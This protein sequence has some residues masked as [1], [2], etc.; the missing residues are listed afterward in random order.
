MYISGEA[1]NMKRDSMP[2]S[3]RFTKQ[4][5]QLLHKKC[6]ELNKQLMAKDKMPIRES[7]LAH[8]IL[9]KGLDAVIVTKSGSL[10]I[11]K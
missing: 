1:I 5:Q 9:E 2:E 11:E 10:E 3:M 6:I 8:L 4:E 7:E